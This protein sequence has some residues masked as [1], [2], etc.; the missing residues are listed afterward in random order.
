MLNTNIRKKLQKTETDRYNTERSHTIYA[1]RLQ[2]QC[3][4]NCLDLISQKLTDEL[5][6]CS[7]TDRQTDRQTKATC[8]GQNRSCSDS[9]AAENDIPGMLHCYTS[10][11][12]TRM[13]TDTQT[14]Y[15]LHSTAA[16]TQSWYSAS[17]SV[18]AAAAAQSMNRH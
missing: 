1:L 7:P 6:T 16:G 5:F 10:M 8:S 2:Q 18:N 17:Y 9:S 15:Q 14:E 12:A 3:L 11:Y 13:S 4:I